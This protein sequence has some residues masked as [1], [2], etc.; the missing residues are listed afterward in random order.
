LIEEGKLNSVID[1]LNGT[2]TVLDKKIKA[3]ENNYNEAK[4]ERDN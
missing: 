2:K 1:K 4:N 3:L